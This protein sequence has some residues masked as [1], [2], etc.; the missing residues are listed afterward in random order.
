MNITC[1]C[2]LANKFSRLDELALKNF[3]H[4]IHQQKRENIYLYYN[5]TKKYQFL[6]TMKLNV[7]YFI[8][9]ITKN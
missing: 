4:F 9:F 7:I 8:F 5:F 1:N 6:S 2:L 3:I